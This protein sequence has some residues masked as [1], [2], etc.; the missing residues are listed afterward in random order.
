MA[1]RRGGKHRA[2]RVTAPW[3]RHAGP[4]G[5]VSGA[6]RMTAP[7]SRA[8]A[9]LASKR[10]APRRVLPRPRLARRHR[11]PGSPATALDRMDHLDR[12]RRR[13]RAAL[14]PLPRRYLTTPPSGRHF[15]HRNARHPPRSRACRPD[16]AADRTGT[17][18][19]YGLRRLADPVT[20][21]APTRDD[22]SRPSDR[23]RPRRDVDRR[24]EQ[25]H[26]HN[27]HGRAVAPRHRP[28]TA[29]ARRA[30]AQRPRRRRDQEQRN[31]PDTLDTE[32][33]AQPHYPC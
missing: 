7:A 18:I 17:L 5:R 6:P 14:R 31:A 13:H 28:S 23:R 19:R 3:W 25:R 26:R 33:H 30:P 9:V 10:L 12:R 29:R 16:R 20:P 15:P 4:T 8:F 21:K 22:R 32:R 1:G 2:D 27:H 11:K 24:R